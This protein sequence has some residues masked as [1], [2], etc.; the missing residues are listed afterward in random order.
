MKS[1][2]ADFCSHWQCPVAAA[3]MVLAGGGKKRGPNN[4][5]QARINGYWSSKGQG[6]RVNKELGLP[7]LAR[8]LIRPSYP[9]G[10]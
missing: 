6:A 2:P 3:V 7:M 8:P 5:R 10:D 9:A 1:G 4:R